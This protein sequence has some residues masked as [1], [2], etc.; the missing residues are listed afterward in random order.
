MINQ[1]RKPLRKRPANAGTGAPRQYTHFRPQIRSRHPSHRPLRQQLIRLPFRSLV[2][3]GSSYEPTDGI[4]RVICNTVEA[5]RNSAN[6]L[7]MKR[8]FS[9]G[10]VKTAKWFPAANHTVFMRDGDKV[11]MYFGDGA[12]N[13]MLLPVVAKSHTGSRGRGNTLIK[14]SDE[15][16]AWARGKDLG[17]YII[18]KYHNYNKE[19]RL[20]VT[21]DGCFYT[22]RKMLREGTPE[23]ERWHRHDS[24]CV[25]IKEDNPSFGKPNNWNNI[26][27][28]CVK[29]LKAVGLDVGACDVKVQAKDQVERGAPDFFIIEINSAPSFG[30][31]TLEKYLVEIPKILRDKRNG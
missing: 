16:R 24:N 29:A 19:Y 30:D 31:L 8:C 20:H 5:I 14:T 10:D 2:R 28:E 25:W 1:S 3:F 26:V 6:K 15:Y 12:E 17:N 23:A 4:A 13:S 9:A 11:R 7:R 21:K 27:S 18:E 22:N